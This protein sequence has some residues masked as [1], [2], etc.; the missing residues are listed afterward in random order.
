MPVGFLFDRSH[1]WG[2]FAGRARY[3]RANGW[4]PLARSAWII[5]IPRD[6][7][8]GDLV[9]SPTFP[10]ARF[11]AHTTEFREQLAWLRALDPVHLYTLP[12]NLEALVALL[13]D[14]GARLRSL[15]GVFTGGEVLDD[16]VRARAAHFG[17]PVA[18]NYRSTGRSS[19]QCP[20]AATA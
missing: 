9:R 5:S 2:R 8:D 14:G 7:P 1:Q 16:T 6:T 17:V 12:S 20:A 3:L 19:W 18:D 10:G 13:D 15:R 11:L 4:S